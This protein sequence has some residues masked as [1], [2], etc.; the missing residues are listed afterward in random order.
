MA[1]NRVR[2]LYLDSAF[3]TEGSGAELTFQLPVQIPT[4]R[5]DALALTCMIVSQRVSAR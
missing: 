4:Q 5:G 1:R 2:K 3:A